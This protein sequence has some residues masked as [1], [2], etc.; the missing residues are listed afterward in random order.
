MI[1]ASQDSFTCFFSYSTSHQNLLSPFPLSSSSPSSFSP[2]FLP[3]LPPSL[4]PFFPSSPTMYQ[5]L[6]TQMKA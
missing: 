2:D 3:S 6:T 5:K 1:R 4:L